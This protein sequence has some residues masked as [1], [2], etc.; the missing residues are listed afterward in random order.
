MTPLFMNN[1]NG[2]KQFILKLRVYVFLVIMTLALF[3]GCRP[4]TVP[5]TQPRPYRNLYPSILPEEKRQEVVFLAKAI[6]PSLTEQD[7]N[8]IIALVGR[9]PKIDYRIIDLRRVKQPIS[10]DPTADTSRVIMVHTTGHVLVM[11]KGSERWRFR[12]IWRY[13]H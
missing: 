7:V 1:L 2:V 4:S 8:E 6:P 11:E 5:T 3:A 9:I 13:Y 12:S 10:M